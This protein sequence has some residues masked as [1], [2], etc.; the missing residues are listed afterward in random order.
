MEFKCTNCKWQGS[1]LQLT[2]LPKHRLA[3]KCPVCGDEVIQDEPIIE[4]KVEAKLKPDIADVNKDGKVDL[5]D[6]VE[7]AKKAFKSKK[8]KRGN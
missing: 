8:K 4:S 2:Q 6:V 7:V 5:S 3:G 1:R